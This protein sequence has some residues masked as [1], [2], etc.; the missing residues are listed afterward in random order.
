MILLSSIRLVRVAASAAL[1]GVLAACA[2]GP[3]PQ[4]VATGTNLAY[5]AYACPALDLELQRVAGALRVAVAEGGSAQR[6]AIPRLASQYESLR[7]AAAVNSCFGALAAPEN[8]AE[9]FARPEG[10]ALASAIQLPAGPRPFEG[11][12]L[13]SFSPAQVDAWCGVA[14]TRRTDP[15]SGRTLYNPCREPEAFRR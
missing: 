1:V 2:S 5:Y 13:S 12:P 9:A 11:V 4:P 14:W 7:E 6:A 10:Q 8:A 3:P 15:G